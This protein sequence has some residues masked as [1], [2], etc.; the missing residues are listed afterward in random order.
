MLL[1]GQIN[2]HLLNDDIVKPRVEI[3]VYP[4]FPDKAASA[5]MMKHA[6]ELA[7]EGTSFLNPSQIAVLGADQPLNEIAKQLQWQYP[8]TLGEDKL[9]LMMGALHISKTKL[10]L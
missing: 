8:E 5:S 9:I 3:G 2:S 4:L 6:M 1:H 7:Q 10:I